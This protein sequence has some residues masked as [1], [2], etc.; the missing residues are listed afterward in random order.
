MR[1][2]WI[3]REYSARM[4]A[5]T[6][7]RP[8]L[9][10]TARH[11]VREA[12]G[13]AVAV[14]ATPCAFTFTDADIVPGGTRITTAPSVTS[15]APTWFDVERIVVPPG[16][17]GC[18]DDVAELVLRKNVPRS[19]AF[20]VDVDFGSVRSMPREVA[21]A[22][23]G[24]IDFGYEL[25]AN[26]DWTGGATKADRGGLLRRVAE[27]V[28]VLCTPAKQACTTLSHEVPAPRIFTLPEE[29]FLIGTAGA[30]GDSG[31]GV[32]EQRGFDAFRGRFARLRGVLSWVFIGPDGS[33]SNGGV[34][35]VDLHRDL[36]RRVAWEAAR[37]GR[38]VLP[39]WARDRE[40]GD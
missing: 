31:A 24:V 37:Q 19:E 18:A 9:V 1:N 21:M 33:P 22:G 5:L 12:V 23:R 32:F 6:A 17:R 35:R 14:S 20:P 3:E 34:V 4:R 39:G 38:Y 13:G 15:G 8:V 27:H 7:Q 25:D 10:L 29:W 28:P 36:L 16:I 40:D 30:P 11:C 26:G 2:M